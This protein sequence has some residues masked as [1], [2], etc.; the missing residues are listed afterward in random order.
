[1]QSEALHVAVGADAGLV[2]GE[3]LL[4]R[5][6]GAAD[7]DAGLGD[8]VPGV[9]AAEARDVVDRGIE[10]DDVDVVVVP[11]PRHGGVA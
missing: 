4:R 1:M 8:V 2:L 11:A 6:P 10:L 5:E 7:V 9:G 3:A